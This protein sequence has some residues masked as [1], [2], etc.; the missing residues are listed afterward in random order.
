MINNQNNY[1]FGS[2]FVINP[3]CLPN[4]ISFLDNW[5]TTLFEKTIRTPFLFVNSLV[6]VYL[7]DMIDDA[8]KVPSNPIN[9][10]GLR[11]CPIYRAA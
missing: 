4:T 5:S 9:A 11:G 6:L 3:N 7:P 8:I 10:I 1:F 2:V